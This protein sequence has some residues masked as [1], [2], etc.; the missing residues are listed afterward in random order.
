MFH[1]CPA[2]LIFILSLLPLMRV[3]RSRL[4]IWRSRCA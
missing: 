1:L 3:W 2:E 4:R